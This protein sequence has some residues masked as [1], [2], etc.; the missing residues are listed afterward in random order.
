MRLERG[1]VA[2][3]V[4]FLTAGTTTAQS[5]RLIKQSD[6]ESRLRGLWLGECIA[7][8]TGLR[9]E[10]SRTSPPFFTDADWGTQP[11]GAHGP[12]VFVT[13]QNPWRADDD[14]DIEYVY[15]HLVRVDATNELSPAQIRDGWIEH[16]NRSIWVSNKSARTLMDRGVTPPGT[17]YGVANPNWLMIDAQL[18]T[19]IFGALAPGMPHEALRFAARPIAT[20]AGS[21]AAMASRFF[22]LLY[23]SAPVA[24]RSLSPHEKNLWLIERARAFMPE[25]SKAAGIVDFVRADALANPDQDDWESTRDKIYARY[26]RDA[27]INGFRY[28]GWYESS[29]NFATAIMALIY[30]QGDYKR[31]IQIGTLSGWD[32]DNPTATLGGLL[33]LLNGEQWVRDA[34]PDKT[35]SSLYWA[36]ATRDNLPD[37]TPTEAGEDRFDLLAARMI[38]MVERTILDAGGLVDDSR[39]QWLLAPVPAVPVNSL[40]P[41]WREWLASANRSVRAGGGVVTATTNI[42]GAPW[43]CQCSGVPA[44]IANGYELDWSGLEPGESGR[45]QFSSRITT[46]TPG[47]VLQLTVEY[48]LPVNART[49]RFIEGDQWADAD[50][51]G[52]FDTL[53]V[54]IR[55]AGVWSSLPAQTTQSESLDPA[56]PFQTI[57]WRL[58]LTV[59][60]VTGVRIRGPVGGSWGYAT[61]LELDALDDTP[62]PWATF[63]LNLDGVVDIEDLYFWRD[64]PIDL[65]GDA[66]ASSDDLVFLEAAARWRELD[67]MSFLRR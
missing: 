29:I 25:G 39:G 58:P 3:L 51:G 57:E 41:N 31:T 15:T 14:T 35:I 64:H 42:V 23:S 54:E 5:T 59:A 63:D 20:T 13:E 50:E 66:V 34:F 48:S 46:P 7:N 4:L 44:C 22:A 47:A 67:D 61:C 24:P 11:T 60:G 56:R 21:H 2:G 10:A 36:T 18:T 43:G 17:A 53:S 62:T 12:I 45:V 8:W 52:W 9:T 27:T 19:E 16:I 26:Q 28:R 65:N 33:G 49:I 37:W 38:P 6:Y 40:D 30:G 1:I 32:S 55:V